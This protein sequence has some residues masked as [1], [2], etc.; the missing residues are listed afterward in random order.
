LALAVLLLAAIL[1]LVDVTIVNVVI[2]TIQRDLGASYEAIQWV[3]AGYTLAFALGLITGGAWATSMDASASF[4]S[5]FWGSRSAR[6]CAVWPLHQRSSSH[7]SLTGNLRGSCRSWPAQT[8]VTVR[9]PHLL[10][11][12]APGELGRAIA[13]RLENIG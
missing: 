9:G 2:P 7:R 3:L 1:D 13:D 10:Q 12:D 6:R 11:E 4:S 5:A 8:E